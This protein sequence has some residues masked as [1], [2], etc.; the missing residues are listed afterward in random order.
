MDTDLSNFDTPSESPLLP[1]GSVV[2]WEG[3]PGGSPSRLGVVL[4]APFADGDYTVAICSPLE[5]A[6]EDAVRVDQADFLSQVSVALP[7]LVRSQKTLP[8]SA[9][10]IQSSLGQL[11]STALA[12]ILRARIAVDTGRFYSAFHVRPHF[13]PPQL[14]VPYAGRVFDARELQLA[15]DASLDFWLTLGP[16][17]DRFG[18]A[19]ARYLGVRKS[20]LVNSGSSANLLAISALTSPLLGGRAL[21]PGDEVI[22]TAGGFPT[23]LNP[24]IQN[25]CVPVLVDNDVGTGNV[26]V[27][28]L[29]EAFSE[30]TRAVILAH[31]LGNPFDVDA[32]NQFCKQHNL[33]LI[34]DNC[35]ALGSVYK[36]SLT[37]SFGDLSTQSFYPPHHLTTGEGGSVNVVSK[38]L[39][40]RIVES[41]RDW[42]RDC[43][44]EAGKDNTCGKRFGWD[45]GDLPAGYD[46]KF[47]YSHIGYNL[48]PTDWQ[49]AIGCA[50]I[51]K[52]PLFVKARRR[53]WDLLHSVFAEYE[54]FFEL[55]RATE[56]T[57]PSWFGFKVLLRTSA[58][59]DRSEL[60]TFLESNCIQTRMLFG[61]NL[62]RQPAYTRV[63]RSDGLPLFRVVGSLDG[64]DHL[65]TSAFFLGVYPGLTAEHIDRVADV[66]QSFLRA[67]KAKGGRAAAAARHQG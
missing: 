41:F 5:A 60:V 22:T 42:G 30:R 43:W 65:M 14:S 59:F 54:E 63:R 51:E 16:Y 35:D 62:A 17:G 7:I 33:W 25:G 11:T 36:S 20:I 40:V 61:G 29:E 19:L 57:E 12:R 37:G 24:I 2:S 56:G 32:V 23:T 52:L 46:H 8:L 45:L 48:K 38:A 47:I 13:N 44:C 6:A 21:R 34:E 50:Q 66:L 10:T 28:Q 49:A 27:D 26:R 15:V 67:R 55:P 18:R 4:S 1:P 3:E 9:K 64:A 31:T 58:P 53:N 39:L